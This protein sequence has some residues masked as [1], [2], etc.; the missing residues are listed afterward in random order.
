MSESFVGAIEDMDQ[1]TANQPLNETDE[2]SDANS[3]QSTTRSGKRPMKIEDDVNE[4]VASLHNISN[5]F[6]KIF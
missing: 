3:T 2:E 4:F 1:E 6:G 5:N